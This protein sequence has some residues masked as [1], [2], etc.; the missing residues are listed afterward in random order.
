MPHAEALIAELD[1][2]LDRTSSARHLTMLR[3]IVDLFL[4][5]AD[6]YSDDQVEVFDDVIG[7][8]IAKVDRG[9]LIELSARLA[10]ADKALVNVIGRLSCD[11][12]IGVS[13]P[14]LE[15]SKALTDQVLVEIAKSKGQDHLAAIAGRAQV[16]E[17]ITDALIERGT[18]QIARKLV[19]NEGARFSEI[20]FVKLINEA[21]RDK[22]LAAALAKRADVPLELQPF[23]SQALA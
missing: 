17:G 4:N 11:N 10:G 13:G 20:G 2:V 5:G 21:S 14:V 12:S 3:S 7:R 8:L 9:G 22:P 16:S 6:G 19:A 15:R 23:L 18:P 1:A